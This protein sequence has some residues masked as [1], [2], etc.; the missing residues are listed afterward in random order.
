MLLEELRLV[1]DDLGEGG[2]GWVGLVDVLQGVVDVL[3]LEVEVKVIWI[4]MS[5]LK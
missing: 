1:S 2:D 4:L 3:D 5:I